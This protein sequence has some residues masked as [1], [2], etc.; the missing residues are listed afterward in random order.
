MYYE[1][2]V[3][4]RIEANVGKKF[5]P[6]YHHFF[7]THERSCTTAE[8]AAEVLIALREAF[9]APQYEITLTKRVNSGEQLNVAEFLTAARRN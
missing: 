1:I 2:N 8:G 9:P 7:A 5:G 6:H 3:A 4:K